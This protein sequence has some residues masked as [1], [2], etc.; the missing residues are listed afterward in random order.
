MS[1]TQELNPPKTHTT[2]RLGE[3]LPIFCEKCGYS[4]NGLTV[5]TCELCKVLHFECPECGHHQPINTLRPA[6]QRILG[7]SRAFVLAIIVFVK[8][9]FFFWLLLAWFMLG[10]SS[11]YRYDYAALNRY[12]NAMMARSNRPNRPIPNVPQLSYFPAQVDLSM[13]F[14]FALYAVP[15]GIF[16]RMLLLR[17]RSAAKIGLILAALVM[18]ALALGA[19]V[20][21]AEFDSA[22]PSPWTLDWLSFELVAGGC[23]CLGC[24]F[25]WPI[26]S[27]LVKAFLPARTGKML[28]EWQKSLSQRAVAEIGRT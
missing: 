7:R 5:T 28:L 4:L 16:A 21:Q 20:R 3:E 26:W 23:V 6:F 15:F 11:S 25:A 17:W 19:I 8:F 27:G 2:Q 14:G 10:A 22:V 9:N 13:M 1:Q 12:N 24:L 18:T